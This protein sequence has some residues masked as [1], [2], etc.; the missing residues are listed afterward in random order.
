MN[1]RPA[2]LFAAPVI[3][4]VAWVATG[5][6]ARSRAHSTPIPSARAVIVTSGQTTVAVYDDGNPVP[7]RR[8]V[9]HADD[10]SILLS[11]ETG[12]DGKAI[13]PIINGAMIT[14]AYGTSAKQLISVAGVLA[15]E[16]ILV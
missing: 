6:P 4:V 2:A 14:V 9:F 13:G 7:K 1:W 11:I 8:V 10:G 15:N 3:A 5:G 16:E 12:A